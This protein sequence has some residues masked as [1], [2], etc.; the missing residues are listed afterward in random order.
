MLAGVVGPRSRSPQAGQ[1]LQLKD[2]TSVCSMRRNRSIVP[3]V[4]QHQTA[5]AS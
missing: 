1:G 2:E 3:A 5:V 4:Q